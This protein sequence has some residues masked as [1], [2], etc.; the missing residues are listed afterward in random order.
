MTFGVLIV[1][2]GQIGMGYDL[3]P[4]PATRICTHARAFS[5]HPRFQLIG[6]VDPDRHQ[7]QLFSQTYGCPAYGDVETVLSQHRP[8]V[9]IIAAP[10]RLHDRVLQQVLE[11]STPKIVLC[12]KP[13]SHDLAQARHMVQSCSDQGVSLYVNYMRRSDPGVAE[14]KRRLEV[15]EMGSPV[16]GVV[17]YSNGFLHNGSHFFNLLE[18][19]LGSMKSSA[20]LNR[21]R[22]WGEADSEPDVQVAF[23]RGDVVFLAARE[24]AFSYCSVELLSPDGRLRYEQGGATI[25]WQPAG[26]DPCLQG[27]TVLGNEP[28]TIVSGMDRYQWQ[29]AAELARVLDGTAAQLCSGTDALQ[30]LENMKRILE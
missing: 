14:I 8:D 26:P 18:Y 28:E 20:I 6:G 3:Q 7:R 25:R 5:R 30:T 17:W 2:L 9:I 29:V 12:E 4:G 11:H 24:E 15:G 16:K 1:G 19:W 27:Y 23:E 13:L 10:T 22:L 21:G